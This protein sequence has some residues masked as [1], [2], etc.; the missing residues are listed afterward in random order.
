MN[1]VLSGKANFGFVSRYKKGQST[2]SGDTKFKF[3]SGDFKFQSTAYDWLVITGSDCAK[4]KGEGIVGDGIVHGFMLT[5]CDNSKSGDADTFWIKIWLA[6]GSVVY[7]NMLGSA[8]DGSYEGTNI[9][10]GDIRVHQGQKNK[11]NLRA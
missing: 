10:G 11:G 1:T 3:K 7:D 8:D 4:Y 5:A 9:D 6:D 2:P